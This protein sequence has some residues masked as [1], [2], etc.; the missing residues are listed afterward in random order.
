M[1]P[2]HPYAHIQNKKKDVQSREKIVSVLRMGT[3]TKFRPELRN[4]MIFQR[5]LGNI[6]N[7]QSFFF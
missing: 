4:I 3:T 6:L 7:F 1:D 2:Y 5:A